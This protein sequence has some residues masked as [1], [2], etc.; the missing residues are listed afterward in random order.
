MADIQLKDVINL[1]LGCEVVLCQDDP[2][3]RRIGNFAGFHDYP[4]CI[5]AR[6]K[7]RAGPDGHT[8]I[9]LLK[10]ILRQLSDMK[11][12]E[13]TEIGKMWTWYQDKTILNDAHF[14]EWH[15]SVHAMVTGALME[16][17]DYDSRMSAK[18]YFQIIPYLLK[19]GFDL[20]DLISRGQAIDKT[21]L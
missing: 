12:E 3:R 19:Q 1:Y 13:K 20:F 5:S 15:K 8:H 18:A 10:P 7:F 21:T 6:I 11:D 16:D 17:G 2:K 4:T 9:F 14:N